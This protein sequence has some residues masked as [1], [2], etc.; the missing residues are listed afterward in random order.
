[1]Q[2]EVLERQLERVLLKVDKP[3]RYVG[4]EWNSVSKNW[5]EIDL[6]VALAFPDIYDLGMSN[7]GIMLLYDQINQQPDML[8]ERVFSPWTDMEDQMRQHGIPL[9]SL[10]SKH[11]IRDFDLLGISLPYEQLYTNVLTMLD[12]AMRHM[13]GSNRLR[14]LVIDLPEAAERFELAAD[15]ADPPEPLVADSL[16]RAIG[17]PRQRYGLRVALARLAG[18]AGLAGL[19]ASLF[20]R[21]PLPLWIGLPLAL[22]GLAVWVAIEPRLRKRPDFTI[23]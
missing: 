7:L 18:L 13:G 8:A 6:K 5:N 12:L 23:R 21:L 9:Y 1:M 20:G 3:G 4:G 16:L 15:L 10:E 19:A 11:A 14:P 17:T 22:L 2:P